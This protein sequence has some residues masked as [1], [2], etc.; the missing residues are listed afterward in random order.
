MK[1]L[2]GEDLLAIHTSVIA[3]SGGS[4]GVRDD[5]ALLS[6]ENSPRLQAFGQE[7]YPTIYLKAAIY[8]REIISQHPY[9]DG[10]KRSGMATSLVFLKLN[11]Y[12]LQL[13][14]ND[15]LDFALKIVLEKLSLEEIAAWLKRHSKK[16]KK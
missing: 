6:L 9:F 7:L 5:H 4:D 8:A 10:N 3:E 11:G 15:I 1:Y 13:H 12:T 14:T 16:T 2:T